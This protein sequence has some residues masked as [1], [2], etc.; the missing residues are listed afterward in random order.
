[1]EKN[2][3][4]A[5]TSPDVTVVIPVPT[6][7]RMPALRWQLLPTQLALLQGRVLGRSIIFDAN[8]SMLL[9][10]A[11]LLKCQGGDSN[12]Y[13][14]LHQILSLARLPIPPPWQ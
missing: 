3:S 7:T 10:L 5:E 13:G 14:F 1:M 12:P 4:D 8:F 11:I 2:V 9:P 6:T